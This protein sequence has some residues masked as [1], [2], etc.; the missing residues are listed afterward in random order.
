MQ[1][2]LYGKPSYPANSTVM[3]GWQL[4]DVKLLGLQDLVGLP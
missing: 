3:N 2:N 1:L 4:V